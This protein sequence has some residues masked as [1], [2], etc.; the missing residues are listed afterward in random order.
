[1]CLD[2]IY[3]NIGPEDPLLG[4]TGLYSS[5]TIEQKPTI[6]F[7]TDLLAIEQLSAVMLA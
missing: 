1:M 7:V 6:A 4:S 5:K 2:D 3:F